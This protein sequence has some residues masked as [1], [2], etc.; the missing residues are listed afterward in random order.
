MVLPAPPRRESLGLSLTLPVS[1]SAPPAPDTSDARNRRTG[2]IRNRTSSR[3]RYRTYRQTS[4][5]LDKAA[6]RKDITDEQLAEQSKR[7]EAA[8][9]LS[10]SRRRSSRRTRGFWALMAEFW[11]MLGNQRRR[12]VGALFISA[13]ATGLGLLPVY[14]TKIVID[15][16]IDNKQWP[17]WIISATQLLGLP[18]GSKH[19]L[20]Y[21][22]VAASLLIGFITLG[23]GIWARWNATKASKQVA[24]QARRIAFDQAVRLPLH[25]VYDIKSGGVTSVLR[26][27]AGGTGELVFSLLYNPSKAI[28][29]LV[30]SLV[31]LA[32]IQW[33]LLVGAI[34]VLPVI[35]VTHK[36]WI[37]RIRPLW[38]DVR[39]TRTHIDAHAT[40]TFGG[41]RVVRT[42]NRQRFEAGTFTENNNLMARQEL[43]TW[44][45][46]RGIEAAW[47]IIIPASVALLLLFGGLMGMQ[48]KMTAGD[49][50]A[51]MAYLLWLLSPI[52]TLA[53]SAT[54]LQ[55]NLAGLD[56][57]LDLLSEPREFSESAGQAELRRQNVRGRITLEN[58]EYAYPK[59][60]GDLG[61]QTLERGELVLHG[62]SLEV[63]AGTTVALVGPSGAGKTTLCNLIAR[64]YDPTAGRILLDGVDL[65]DINIDSYRRLLSI[66]EQDTF[67]FD[68]TIAENIAYGRRDATRDDVINAARLANAHEFIAAFP[69]G[70]EAFI[71]E[72]GVKLSGGQ[73]Q[74]LTIARA[75]LADPKILILDEATSNLD[76]QSERLIQAS[77]AELMRGRTSFVIAHR[78]STIQ[79]ADLIAVVE[80]GRIIETGTHE[81]LMGRSGRYRTMVELQ[82]AP[83]APLLKGRV[84][85]GE[86]AA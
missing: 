70:Y 50:M 7:A 56:R 58:V 51:F 22:S 62:V 32:F 48:Q 9:N 45:W 46:S 36:T 72:R 34:V 78:L 39:N 42:F 21:A 4:R 27:D 10:M 20:L 79:G 16:V 49:L 13:I 33:E 77:L 41:M 1:S 23:L 24:I 85:S 3:R 40:E 44:W 73:R 43:L 30:G 14:A 57:T 83:P 69:E 29:Q 76:T 12:V 63:P 67:L 53:M 82:T 68:G 81:E 37:A 47:Q 84:V 5:E 17:G 59:Q 31:I 86:A 18:S 80:Q 26:D 15:Y 11:R 75:M 61:Q 19:A 2:G 35:W 28:V 38:R 71:G 52:A 25:R 74:R 66:V 60:T 54:A 55:N 8:G 64:F 6:K 65:R